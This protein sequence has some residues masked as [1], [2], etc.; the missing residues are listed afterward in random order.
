MSHELCHIFGLKHCYYFNC[1]MNESNSIAEAATQPLFLCP[2]CLR[3]MQKAVGFDPLERYRQLVR[4]IKQLQSAVLE[5]LFS[6]ANI[7]ECNNIESETLGATLEVNQVREDSERVWNVT[8][9]SRG[10]VEVHDCDDP[11]DKQ[12]ISDSNQ[13]DGNDA[14]MSGGIEHVDGSDL[15]GCCASRKDTGLTDNRCARSHSELFEEAIVWLERVVSSLGQFEDQ[16]AGQGE[17]EL[18]KVCC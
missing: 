13:S 12:L 7:K 5:A 18:A 4:V 10:G 3:K 1:A 16:W 17:E 15:Q 6:V 9:A 14:E 8:E 2:I 11:R